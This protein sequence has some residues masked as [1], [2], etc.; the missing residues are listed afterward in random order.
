M[1]ERVVLLARRPE[2]GNSEIFLLPSV[3]QRRFLDKEAELSSKQDLFRVTKTMNDSATIVT[4][5][6]MRI[7]LLFSNI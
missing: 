5:A 3:R 2:G 1:S 4:A 7:K 6:Q